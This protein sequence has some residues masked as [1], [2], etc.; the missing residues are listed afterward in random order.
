MEKNVNTSY[1]AQFWS[2]EA[3]THTKAQPLANRIGYFCIGL[4]PILRVSMQVWQL[5]TGHITQGGWRGTR[6][7]RP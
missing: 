1:L 7:R 6:K 4:N 5:L 3:E 2:Q